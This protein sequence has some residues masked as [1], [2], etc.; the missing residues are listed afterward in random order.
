MSLRTELEK[1]LETQLDKWQ[2]DIDEME[3]RAK[4]QEAEAEDEKQSAALQKETHETLSELKSAYDKTKQKLGAIQR[5]GGSCRFFCGRPAANMISC[6]LRY[7]RWAGGRM[8]G[9]H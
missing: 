8:Q 7:N 2:A 4:A 9:I 5:G 6:M 1:K 3:A